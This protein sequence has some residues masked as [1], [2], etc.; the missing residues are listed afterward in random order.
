MSSLTTWAR[1]QAGLLSRFRPADVLAP[2][3]AVLAEL[4]GDVRRG[5]GRAAQLTV[6]DLL[7]SQ[8]VPV[9]A[10]LRA[11]PRPPSLNGLR[12]LTRSRD[13]VAVLT[14]DRHYRVTPYAGPMHRLAGP[15]ALALDGPDHTAARERL[16][17]VV[18]PID[19][20]AVGTWA[21]TA[22]ARL[23]DQARPDGRLDVVTELAQPLAVQFVATWYGLSAGALDPAEPT[24]SLGHWANALFEDCF[25]N[26]TRDRTVAERATRAGLQMR[27]RAVGAYRAH[28]MAGSS[29]TT[30]PDTVVARMVADGYDEEAAVSDLMGLT[31]A[32]VPTVTEAIMR[33]VDHLLDDAG[34]ARGARQAAVNG[35]RDLL[36]R[37]ARESLRF[38]PQSPALLRADRTGTPVMVSTR[39]AMHDPSFVDRPSRYQTDRPERCYLHF[40]A[41]PHTCLGRDLAREL[42]V[43]AMAVLLQEPRL[44]RMPGPSGRPTLDGPMP[45]HLVVTV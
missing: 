11:L 1:E 40:G 10:L 15:F 23:V 36:W 26:L 20:A 45:A 34:A 4:P 16:H 33:V 21:G 32:T 6:A 19:L 17:G 25:L 13:V 8:P 24:E 41:G 38:R 39:S 29:T 43:S 9:L 42:T 7:A 31:V 30:S 22:C 5:L 35:D 44:R 18:D 27:A 28:A 37:H 12:I 14:D 2:S 3:R